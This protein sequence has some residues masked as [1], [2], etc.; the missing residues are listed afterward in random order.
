MDKFF[1]GQTVRIIDASIPSLIG[2]ITTIS[3]PVRIRDYT[4][5]KGLVRQTKSYRLSLICPLTKKGYLAQE[6][7][8]EPVRD[9]DNKSNWQEGLWKPKEL[10]K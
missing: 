4:T 7:Y 10:A 8:L 2:T 6:S 1:I 9:Q 5:I 3:E